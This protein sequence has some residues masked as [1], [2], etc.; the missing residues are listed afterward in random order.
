M[1]PNLL[2]LIWITCKTFK[3]IL[4]TILQVLM[5]STDSFLMDPEE[6]VEV[7]GKNSARCAENGLILGIPK[8]ATMH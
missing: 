1:V 2:C 8:A 3:W 7:I 6:L 5:L 4:V